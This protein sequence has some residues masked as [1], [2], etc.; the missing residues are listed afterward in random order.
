[1][2]S[3]RKHADRIGDIIASSSGGV[4]YAL[5]IAAP[6]SM[7]GFVMNPTFEGKRISMYVFDG[8]R[9]FKPFADSA[10]LFA[11]VVYHYGKGSLEIDLAQSLLK[12]MNVGGG[13]ELSDDELASFSGEV[14]G[15]E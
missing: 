5:H 4:F 8:G 13:V 9:A 15:R 1:M 12:Q 2:L 11:R 6:S 7:I 3:S 10:R 14:M